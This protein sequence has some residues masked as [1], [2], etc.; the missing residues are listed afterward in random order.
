M[1]DEDHITYG[2]LGLVSLFAL[3]CLYQA[4]KEPKP[5][6]KRNRRRPEVLGAPS[7]ACERTFRLAER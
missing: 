7:P 3:W 4:L 6:P 1:S 5:K 2:V